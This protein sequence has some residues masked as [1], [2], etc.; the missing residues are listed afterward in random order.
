MSGFP[1]QELLHATA[2]ELDTPDGPVGVLLR[3]P[4]GSGKSDLALR[5]IDDG[6]RLVADDQT[7]LTRESDRVLARAPAQLEGTLEVRGV[8]LAGVP[9]AAETTICLVVELTGGTPIDRLPDEHSVVLLGQAVPALHLDAREPS[10]PAKL[11]LA[12]RSRA[13]ALVTP[14]FADKAAEKG[15]QALPVVLVTGLSGAGRTTALKLLEDIGYEAIDN[16]PLNL[17]GPAVLAGHLDRPVALGADIR[18]RDFAAQ[19]FLK[20]LDA[21]VAEPALEVKLVFMDCA[22]DVLQRRFTETRRR[23]PLAQERPLADGLAAERTMT[24]PLKARADLVVDTS[25]LAVPDFRRLITGHFGLGS[26]GLVVFVTSFSFRQGLPR[27]ADLVLDVRFLRNPH[28]VEALQPL[29]GRDPRVSAYVAN[30][31]AFAGF[32]SNLTALIEPL[33]PRYEAEGKSYLTIAIGCTGGKHRSVAIAEKLSTWL[34]AQGRE[35]TVGHRDMP[36]T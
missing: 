9:S 23:H 7:Q 36:T 10:A 26:G 16:L 19:P 24:A 5:L 3:G 31:P 32:F 33:L 25:N 29:T 22:D 20:Q 28:Y 30:D 4:S 13:S 17:L 34:T 15:P 11:R 6:A 14:F 35:V 21:L 1:D 2:V 27:E 12:A 18:N 8:G